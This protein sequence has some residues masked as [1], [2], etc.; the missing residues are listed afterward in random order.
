MMIVAVF[1]SGFMR[2]SLDDLRA[3]DDNIWLYL[4]GLEMDKPE[5]GKALDRQLLAAADERAANTEARTRFKMRASYSGNYFAI[6][7][8]LGKV[9][10]WRDSGSITDLEKYG[11]AVGRAFIIGTAITAGLT[12][13]LLLGGILAT[14]RPQLMVGLALAMFAMGIAWLPPWPLPTSNFWLFGDQNHGRMVENFLSFLADPGPGFVIFGFTPRSFFFVLTLLVFA[15]RWRGWWF[16]AYVLAL[17]LVFVHESYAALLLATMVATDLWFR[18]KL[19]QRL[20]VLLTVLATFAV[21]IRRETL[22]PYILPYWQRFSIGTVAL[23]LVV[24]LL[25]LA[26]GWAILLRTHKV[27]PGL[28]LPNWSP[29]RIDCLSLAVI[30]LLTAP[31]FL[32]ASQY[33]SHLQGTYFWYQFDGRLLALYEPV[34]IFGLIAGLVER[35]WPAIQRHALASIFGGWAIAIVV[36]VIAAAPGF[37]IK[38]FLSEMRAVAL[39]MDQPISTPL[40]PQVEAPIYLAMVRAIEGHPE[41]LSTLLGPPRGFDLRRVDGETYLERCTGTPRALV[42]WLHTWN[43]DMREVANQDELA[44]LPDI[45][46]ISPNFNGPAGSNSSSC[47]SLDSI[48]RIRDAIDDVRTRHGNLP[49][50]VAGF[51]GGG[52]HALLTLGTYPDLIQAASLWMPDHDLVHTYK[53]RP[54][55]QSGLESCFD[56]PPSD[57]ET[58]YLVNAPDSVL[59]KIRDVTVILN[60]GKTDD[61]VPAS[62]V[63][64]TYEQMHTACQTCRIDL[65]E[66]DRGHDYAKEDLGK[67]IRELMRGLPYTQP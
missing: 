10:Q 11:R 38:P 17:A 34:I 27:R 25:L 35:Y 41:Q 59:S 6:S 23:A 61:Q 53:N 52:F 28:F 18:P 8:I 1:V 62:E 48:S 4:I 39:R 24:V 46:L 32:V 19:F 50:V 42:V 12:L 29:A 9:A 26:A 44:A 33:V 36:V 13:L 5:L 3:S 40:G 55:L 21:C 45:C 54:D 30:W 16:G 2:N 64:R 15:W 63:R 22:W 20:P 57:N 51:S 60:F 43:A 31:I 37:S 47:G 7:W 56:G 14:G 67:Q 49:A 65:R 58:Q 66:W